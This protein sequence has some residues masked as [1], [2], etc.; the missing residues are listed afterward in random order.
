MRLT[1]PSLREIAAGPEDIVW[2]D[3]TALTVENLR[4]AYRSGIFP[5]PARP[6][7]PIP[8]CSPDPRA[9]LVFAELTP[10]RTLEKRSDAAASPL[11][12]TVPSP[13]S[14]P[15]APPPR[16]PDKTARGSPRPSPPPTLRSTAKASPTA[17]K[18][19]AT[20][21]SSAA[22][23]ASMPADSSAAKACFTTSPTSQNSPSS[24]SWTT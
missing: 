24:T 6:H 20:K 15:P 3:A 13:P 12:S 21:N 4:D 1:F 7:E 17:S 14:S 11:P 23:T 2:T 18:S 19:G 22:S 16:A 9:V 5:W 10:G 8:W